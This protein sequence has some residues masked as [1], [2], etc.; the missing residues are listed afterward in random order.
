MIHGTE[1]F[2]N[3]QE[4]KQI[5]NATIHVHIPIICAI[6]QSRGSHWNETACKLVIVK[7]FSVSKYSISFLYKNFS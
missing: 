2:L 1:R 3:I 7:I 4:K 5:T 6:Q